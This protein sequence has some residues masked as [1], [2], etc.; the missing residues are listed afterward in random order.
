MISAIRKY[1]AS[2]AR[3]VDPARIVTREMSISLEQFAQ[4]LPAISRGMLAAVSD[5]PGRHKL[6]GADGA[7]RIACTE[8]PDRYI[9]SLPVPVLSVEFDFSGFDGQRSDAVR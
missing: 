1:Y 6:T 3:Q 7:V 4:N 5:A 8:K 2:S 9:G